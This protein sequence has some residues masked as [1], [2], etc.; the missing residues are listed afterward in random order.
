M[1]LHAHLARG[2]ALL[3]GRL[4]VAPGR[5]ARFFQLLLRSHAGRQAAHDGLLPLLTRALRAA[6]G[7]TPEA[8][9]TRALRILDRAPDQLWKAVAAGV[10]DASELLILLVEALGHDR[11]SK[12]SLMY[13]AHT[14]TLTQRGDT[15]TLAFTMET[16]SFETGYAAGRAAGADPADFDAHLKDFFGA[17][18]AKT[19]ARE[20]PNW[21]GAEELSVLVFEG[22]ATWTFAARDVLGRL[23]SGDE[24]QALAQAAIDVQEK[25]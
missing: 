1:G 11:G 23:F 9:L 3:E 25:S 15:L 5:G 19:K 8:R 12:L 14:A 13:D 7:T 16:A 21:Q 18:S 24:L 17:V 22:T 4:G 20:Q 10:E 2:R 6:E